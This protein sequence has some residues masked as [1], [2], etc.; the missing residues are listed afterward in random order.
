MRTEPLRRQAYTI[1]TLQNRAHH[2]ATSKRPL[3][4]IHVSDTKKRLFLFPLKYPTAI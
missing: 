3:N 1:N 2:R 4:N